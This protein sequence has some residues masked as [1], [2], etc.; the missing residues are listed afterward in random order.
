M[1]NMNYMTDKQHNS[2]LDPILDGEALRYR[3]EVSVP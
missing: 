2:R 3:K 1:R